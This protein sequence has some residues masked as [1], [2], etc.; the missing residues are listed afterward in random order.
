MRRNQYYSFLR[1][2][3]GR[4]E[5]S[6]KNSGSR[7]ILVEFHGSHSLV[8]FSGYVRLAVS[9]FYTKMSQRFF[10]S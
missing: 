7:I 9:F 6:F 5:W 8:F 4:G 2:G 10:K 1:G 3:G